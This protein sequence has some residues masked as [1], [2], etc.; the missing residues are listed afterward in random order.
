[1]RA[2]REM[3]IETVAVYSDADARALHVAARRPGGA[4]RPAQR[5]PRAT[6]RIDGDPRRGPRQPARKRCI[7]ATASCRRTTP[8]PRPAPPP[9]SRSSGRLARRHGAMGSKT[10]ARRLAEAA[11]VPVVP[12]EVPDDQSDA[13]LV[14]RGHA[15][16]LPG[17][18]QAV[19]RRRRHRHE[20]RARRRAI[21]SRPSR[22][23][24]ARRWRRSATAR[25]MWSGW[26][27][28][29]RHVEF[30]VLGD[31]TATSCTCSSASARSSAAT[32][33]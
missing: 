2:C 9:A 25:C 32:R 6:C 21:S 30:Q 29:P 33:R 15:G 4:H 22:R 23:P 3:G 12:G 24:D 20:G 13:A 26:C 31:A 18:A 14:G 16:R 19:G 17:A 8:L 5:R 11:G 7:R 10:A 1:M 28:T 27:T